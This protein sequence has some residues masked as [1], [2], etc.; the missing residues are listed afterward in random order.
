MSRL[1]SLLFLAACSLTSGSQP[2][3]DVSDGCLYCQSYIEE[4][5]IK[6]SNAT[7]VAAMTQSLEKKC[8][9]ED[10]LA[11]K[12][13]CTAVVDALV[14][15]PPGIFEGMD[16]LAWPIPLA[17]CA[18][19]LKC[20]V[21]CC[22]ADSPPEQIHLSLASTDRSLMGV[23]W[24]T[25]NQAVSEVQYGTEPDN[26]DMHSSGHTSTYTSAGWVGIIHKA[27]MQNLKPSTT[28]YY[29]VGG[30]EGAANPWSETI[31]FTTSVPGQ[32]LR[33]AM[34]ADMAYDNI[35]DDTVV[36]L[37]ELTNAGKLDCVVHSGDESYADGY[38][39]HWDDFFNKIQPIASKVPYMV[40]PGNHEF[41]YNFSSYKSRFFMPGALVE[42]EYET[43][44]GRK[45][46]QTG[47]GSGDNMYYSWEMGSIHF[48]SMNSETAIDTANFN[49]KEL[50]WAES[51]LSTV[52]RTKTPWLIANL[53]RPMYCSND[54]ECTSTHGGLKLRA[55]AEDMF[56]QHKVDLVVCGHVHSYERTYPVY[57][58]TKLEGVNAGPVYIVQG[59][60]GNR[61]GNKGSFPSPEN[62]PAWSAAQ[63]TEVGYA[64]MIVTPSSLDWTFY[65]SATRQALDH[66][67]YSK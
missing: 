65:D 3:P 38:E 6:W 62:L 23:S 64:V 22:G 17:T 14:Q 35:S 9:K 61:E 45:L 33:F 42:E 67:V 10:G 29:R 21:N 50:A 24:V 57:N 39:P 47:S 34:I 40:T 13:I 56:Y 63:H 51:D 15:I 32:P 43:V 44:D 48:I 7:T 46:S 2:A 26:L 25:L 1:K 41:W 37:I 12:K 49:D 11:K 52:D 58:N 66:V 16:S 8:K 53:H 31:S 30:D 28:Y 27:V 54:N 60:S 4:L 36:A 59:A 5:D 55:E 20:K 18:T 19:V